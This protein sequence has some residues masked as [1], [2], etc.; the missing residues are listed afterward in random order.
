LT[1]L[2]TL[3]ALRVGRVGCIVRAMRKQQFWNVDLIELFKLWLSDISVF[4]M[5][6]LMFV[7]LSL[8]VIIPALIMWYLMS[9]NW[10]VSP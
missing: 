10:S 8:P 4:L 2:T 3:T 6:T 5:T 1:T 9:H 7:G